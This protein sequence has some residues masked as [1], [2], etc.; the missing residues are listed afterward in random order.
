MRISVSP[1]GNDTIACVLGSRCASSRAMGATMH[2]PDN[3]TLF[4][5]GDLKY[6]IHLIVILG[7]V[8]LTLFARFQVK[9][10]ERRRN[11]KPPFRQRA[12]ASAETV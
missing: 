6:L 12:G 5:E 2:I 1:P 10:S 7:V 11:E 8:V 4:F 3:Q 9:R